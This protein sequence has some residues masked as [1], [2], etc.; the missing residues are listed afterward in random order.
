MVFEKF[1]F[2]QTDGLITKW[3]NRQ[4]KK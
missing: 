4:L 2:A 3:N 1:N